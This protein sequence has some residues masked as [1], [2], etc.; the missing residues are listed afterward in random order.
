MTQLL[1]IG[2]SGL[3]GQAVLR[4]ALARPQVTQVVAPTRTPLGPT[5]SHPKLH[6]PVIDF[7]QLPT[8][9]PWW[10]ASAAISTMGTTLKKAGSAAAFT[11]VDYELVLACAKAARA[12][13]TR[14][15]VNNSSLGAN[16]KAAGLYLR[17]K[18]ELERD[19]EK[20]GFATVC[21][22]RPSLL[23]GEGQPG[24]RPDGRPM[25]QL[26]LSLARRLAPLIPKRYRAVSVERV[27]HA[28]LQEAL[29]PSPGVSVIESDALQAMDLQA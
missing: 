27:A 25:E 21:H 28:L 10:H 12:A 17:V 15:F 8:Q 24:T 7:T 3:V 16:P 9:A 1:L 4:Q 5:W 6:N 23:D 19:L 29:N 22:V 13:G 11:A 14:V 2:A 20:Q 18:G 26:S